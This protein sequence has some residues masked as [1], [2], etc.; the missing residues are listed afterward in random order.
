MKLFMKQKPFSFRARFTVKD[1]SEQ[2]VYTVS[3]ER[4]SLGKKL[5]FYDAAGNMIGSVRQK[6]YFLRPR[7]GLYVNEVM[8][9]ELTRDFTVAAP[10]FKLNGIDWDISSDFWAHTY[11]IANG[12]LPVASISK[13]WKTLGD[14]YIMDIAHYEDALLV[15]EIMVA[16]DCII[17]QL[18]FVVNAGV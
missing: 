18:S 16:I 1:E 15:I 5:Y 11:E 3:S 4:I 6:S 10:K 17:E 12:I 8:V 7:Y 14:S 13:E 2:T 9:A